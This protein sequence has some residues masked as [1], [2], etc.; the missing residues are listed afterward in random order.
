MRVLCAFCFADP[1]FCWYR[2]PSTTVANTCAQDDKR[3]NRKVED[4]SGRGL[5]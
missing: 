4:D 2:G 1:D 5:A 3:E